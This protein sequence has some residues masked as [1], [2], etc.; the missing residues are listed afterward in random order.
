MLENGRHGVEKGG[1]K[2]DDRGH[3]LPTIGGDGDAGPPRVLVVS[4][5]MG[6][7]HDG[8][9]RELCRRLEERGAQT[10]LVDFLDAAPLVGRLLLRGYGA[11]LRAAPWTY[12]ATYRI[13]FLVPVLCRPLVAVLAMVFGRRLRRW[14]RHQRAD[15]VVSTYPLASVVL[16]HARRRRRLE[17]PVAT[18]LTDFAVHPLSVHSHVDM[19]L[20]VHE[21]SARLAAEM[22]GAATLAP[23]PLVAPPFRQ[24]PPPRE[25]ARAALGLPSGR[26]IVL[27]VAGSW[28]VGELE[29]TFDAVAAC[30]H[31]LPVV[32]CGANQRL[33]QRL[34]ARQTGVVIGWTDQMSTLMAA[35]DVLVQ[36]AGGLTCMEAFAV[37]L[38]V[39]SFRPIPG[40][41][42]Q[43]AEDM[44]AAEVAAYVRDQ[45]DLVA[46]LDRA[47]TLAGQRSARRA[48]AMFAGD[49]AREVAELA[50]RRRPERVRRGVARRVGAVALAA[51]FAYA[52]IN[53]AADAAVAHG[54]G[55]ARP[56][57]AGRAVYLAV[58]IG[59]GTM[60]DPQ[61]A[62]VLERRRVTAVVEGDAALR[63]P[64]AV[65]HL[66][67]AGVSLANGG[68][69]SESRFHVLVDTTGVARADAAIERAAG[70]RRQLVFAPEQAVNG[71]DLATARLE[72]EPIVRPSA[73]LSTHELRTSRQLAR[74]LAPAR[75]YVVDAE[76][77]T[78]SQ[79]D[80]GLRRLTAAIDGAHLHAEPMSALA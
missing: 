50:A 62:A 64:G 2:G 15:A 54:V 16:G 23:G 4:A 10:R 17:A 35:A 25:A 80:A 49:A 59:P 12:E 61:M 70:R 48:R 55:T 13:W 77:A 11:Q 71:F 63:R 79:L 30:E 45:E 43:N 9:A 41:G 73:V 60:S 32:V 75:I 37:G 6:A 47:T 26:A 27:V 7:G 3:G 44:E 39:V 33:R 76:G 38:P 8:A 74:I 36:N 24:T 53:V 65:R 51:S 14:A 46:A 68:W 40:H 18:F 34:E 69:G 78:P 56:S 22:S 57:A 28:G 72:H 58:R 29:R 31:Y 42:R 5:R 21:Q 20:C 67:T 52:G 19:Q 1:P 66:A